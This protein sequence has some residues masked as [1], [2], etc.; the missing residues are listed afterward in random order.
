MVMRGVAKAL[1]AGQAVVLLMIA[2]LTFAL[3]LLGCPR[4]GARR[5]TWTVWVP[6]EFQA[7]R[8][9][10]DCVRSVLKPHCRSLAAANRENPLGSEFGDLVYCGPSVEGQEA[11]GQFAVAIV[12]H[13][14]RFALEFSDD[15]VRKALTTD[16]ASVI[17]G[18]LTLITDEVAL[19][20]LHRENV[21]WIADCETYPFG[22]TCPLPIHGGN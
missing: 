7:D 20:C 21:R 10:G 9:P 14:A 4:S 5:R 15:S 6:L 12:K 16:K 18:K 13:A 2:L 19:R 1:P 17:A 11:S 3:L 8:H 22:E